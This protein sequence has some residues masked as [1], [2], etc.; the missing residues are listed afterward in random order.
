M[1]ST[2]ESATRSNKRSRTNDGA[3]SRRTTRRSPDGQAAGP[4][5]VERSNANIADPHHIVGSRLE[6]IIEDLASQPKSLQTTII[7]FQNSMLD[8]LVIIKQRKLSSLRFTKPVTDPKTGK[9]LTD[10]NGEP[11]KFVPNSCRSKCPV[12]APTSFRDDP[13][14]AARLEAA[15]KDHEAWKT[16]MSNHAKEVSWLEI[17]L[18]EEEMRG[19]FFKYITTVS[20]AW[21]IAHNARNPDQTSSFSRDEWGHMIAYGIISSLGSACAEFFDFYTDSPD[22]PH[23]MSEEED[24][25]SNTGYSEV[26]HDPISGATKLGDCYLEVSK[27]DLDATKK[28]SE[29]QVRDALVV[30]ELVGKILNFVR[31]TTIKFWIEI[32]R[33]RVEKEIEA[34]IKRDLI[35]KSITAA[36]EATAQVLDQI[37][38][39]NPSKPLEDYIDKRIKAGQTKLRRE[40][41]NAQRLN[42]S[43]DAKNQESTPTENGTSS[44]KVRFDPSTSAKAPLKKKDKKKKKGGKKTGPPDREP[45]GTTKKGTTKKTKSGSQGGP[46]KGGK[47]SGA[48]RR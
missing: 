42:C 38:L 9:G 25:D 1:P 40:L 46:K 17:T 19:E 47:P 10:E 5:I 18:R 30:N 16:T 11:K 24:G 12:E 31:N 43:G 20:R 13:R 6:P 7:E 27:F 41:K 37:D 35:P 4:A 23:A 29:D 34:E 39:A 15:H 8:K 32:D 44:K 28:K 26:G 33:L 14:M 45:N 36:T 22:T 21:F 2:S 3:T 48:A